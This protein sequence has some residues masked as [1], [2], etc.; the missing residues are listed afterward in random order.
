MR[1]TPL[2]D[3]REHRGRRGENVMDLLT[4]AI[5]EHGGMRTWG[6]VS[7]FRA[8]AAI[9]GDLWKLKGQDGLLDEVVIEGETR[10]Q[11]LTIGPFPHAGRYAT[12][13]PYRQMI[14]TDDGV[15][16]A[17]CRD[18]VRAFTRPAR[19]PDWNELRVAYFASQMAWNLLTMP[20]LF[21]RADFVTE[22]IGTWREDGEVWRQLAVTY[23]DCIATHTRRQV[24]SFDNSGFLCRIDYTVDVLG[25]EPLVHYP[26]DYCEFDG[27]LVPMRHRVYARTDDGGADLSTPFL[28]VDFRDVLFS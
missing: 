22:E 28:A 12:W 5:E 18:P 25:G 10:D 8:P 23:P 21:A 24:F 11:R 15:P 16:V 3:E 26:A 19:R 14:K 13:E 20:F 9:S 17:E 4:M 7:R 6:R 27:I 1:T 2:S